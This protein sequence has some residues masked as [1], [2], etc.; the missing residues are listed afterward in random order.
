[1][2][3]RILFAVVTSLLLFWVTGYLMAPVDDLMWLQISSLEVSETVMDMLWMGYYLFS[4]IV[5][6]AVCLVFIRITGREILKTFSWKYRNNGV[7]TLLWGMA[8]GFVLNGILIVLMVLTGDA[9]FSF[10][11]FLF[12]PLLAVLA[13]GI[14]QCSCEELLYR[15]YI[16]QY[17]KDRCGVAAAVLVGSVTF[18]LGHFGN[19]MY[20]GFA[21]AFLMNIFLL[22]VVFALMMRK[23]GSF[24]FACGVHT[25][26]NFT[27]QYLFGL[28]NS[29]VTSLG[30]VFVGDVADN[31]FFFDSVFGIEGSW[32]C[33]VILGLLTVWLLIMEQKKPV[34]F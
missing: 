7:K 8:V 24:W 19:L 17:L 33:T 2:I 12:F 28:P 10:S 20:Y 31:S 6:M 32:G 29:G 11:E 21:P 4:Y 26:W 27:Q 15:G 14:V 16:Y 1:M 13:G 9:S 18:L 5:P 22:G 23:T 25:M 30:A 3:V 34:S